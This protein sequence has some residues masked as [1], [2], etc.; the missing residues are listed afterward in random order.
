MKLPITISIPDGF[1]NEEI[2]CGYKVSTKMKAVWAVEL[3]LYKEL[4]RV[5]NKYNLK[6][7]AF[8]GTILGAVRHRGFIPW[9]DDMDFAMSRKDYDILCEH[10]IEEFSY[11]YYFNSGNTADISSRGHGQL[12]NSLTTCILNDE[13]ND[14][15]CFNQGIYIDIFV[16]DNLVNDTKESHKYLVWM[17][18]QNARMIRYKYCYLGKDYS[19]GIKR[20]F[21]KIYLVIF[22]LWNQ[23]YNNRAFDKYQANKKKYIDL[24]TNL[25]V[26][27]QFVK[28]DNLEYL[29]FEKSLFSNVISID[30]E[31]LSLCIPS[32]Y[33][34]YLSKAYGDWKKLVKGNTI[35]GQV[36][37]D[38][39]KSYTYYLKHRNEIV[40]D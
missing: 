13:N 16:Y 40:F 5:C 18:K 4:E 9:D 2:R 8:A 38:P 34:Y 12:K 6:L 35:H 25:C 39:Y 14:K 7:F 1:L 20:F 3:D 36:F 27:L 29:V 30:Y 26:F 11:P 22:Y 28:K 33:Q 32:G 23:E 37:L 10:A 19:Y 21:K 15:C 24:D 31:F 17:Q